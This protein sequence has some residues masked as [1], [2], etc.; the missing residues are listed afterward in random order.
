MAA[1]NAHEL[2][3]GDEFSFDE[4]RT[5]VICRS[6]DDSKEGKGFITVHYS[7]DDSPGW[8]SVQTIELDSHRK[9]LT[10]RHWKS[11]VT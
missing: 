5:W 8:S 7:A 11:G 3:R 2:E 1:I 9:V 4:G 6:V 10:D